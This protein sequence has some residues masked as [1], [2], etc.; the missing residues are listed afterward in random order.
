MLSTVTWPTL[1]HYWG[2]AGWVYGVIGSMLFIV[3]AAWVF[4]MFNSEEIKDAPFGS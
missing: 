1:L 4:A 3:W 2:A